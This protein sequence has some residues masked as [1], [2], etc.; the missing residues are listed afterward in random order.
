MSRIIWILL[1]VMMMYAIGCGY[2]DDRCWVDDYR[3][4]TAKEIYEKTQ[5]LDLV[6]YYLENQHTWRR[7]EINEVL[8]RLKKEY[9]LEKN[10][11]K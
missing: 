5:T 1:L 10:V 8:Y 9:N 6:R 11:M 4:Q 2:K 7:C 3:Y